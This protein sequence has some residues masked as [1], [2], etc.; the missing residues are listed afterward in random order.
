MSF[1][2]SS[3]VRLIVFLALGSTTL[4]VALSKLDP[5]TPVWRTRVATRYSNLNEYFMNFTERTPRWL[6]AESGQ[7]LS[8][9]LDDADVLEAASSAPWVDDQGEYQVAGRWSSRTRKGPMSISTDFGLARY[10]FPS[11]RLLDHVSTEIVPVCPPCWFP[12]TR[13]RI[14]FAG[15]DGELYH[16][17]FESELHA[18]GLETEVNRD[19][20]PTLVEWACPKP[21]L[22]KVFLSDLSWPEDP[23]LSGYVVVSLREQSPDTEAFRTFSGATLWWLKLNNAG[24]EIVEAGRLNVSDVPG[25]REFPIDQRSPT[26]GTL[27][28]GKPVVAYLVENEDR[29]SWDLRL[30]PIEFEGDHHLPKALESKSVRLACNCQPAHPSFTK[31]GRWINA[32]A[33]TTVPNGRILRLPLP[34]SF[35]P[36]G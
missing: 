7:I 18:K 6:D 27:A 12:G 32:V 26:V 2:F 19:D 16:Y 14:L 13:A 28:D 33:E 24:T 35:P 22:G 34:A 1:S 11:G 8:T 25:H 3:L 9:P 10:S 30:A 5:P 17:A 20:R 4:A 23:R 21:G 36:Q 29:K 15:G 31:D